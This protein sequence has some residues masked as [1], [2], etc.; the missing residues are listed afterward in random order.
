[1]SFDVAE[2][3]VDY[4][5]TMQNWRQMA[6][7]LIHIQLTDNQVKLF[8]KYEELLLEWNQKINLTAIRDAEGIRKKHFLDSLSCILAMRNMDTARVIDVGTGAGF[9]GLPLKIIFPQM[10]LTLV[11]SI[12]KKARFCKLVCDTLELKDVY[13]RP[14]RAEDVVRQA[15]QRES[16]DWAVA[17]AVANLPVLLEYTLPFVKVGG[18][19]LAQKGVTAHVEA[20]ASTSAI[21]IL[22]G[23][24]KQIQP[25]QIPGVTEDRFLVV[26]QKVYA[27]PLNYPRPAGQPMKKPIA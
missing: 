10:Q 27:T 15:G 11:E 24:L 9:P 5:V 6:E 23:K 19:V 18:S 8:Q 14:Q 20:Q 25:V 21:Q 26:I 1:M 2:H 12:G 16:Y 22:G 13:I 3:T 17:R 4:N 7:D